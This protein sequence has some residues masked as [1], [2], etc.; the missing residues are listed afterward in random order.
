MSRV[1]P[2]TPQRGA[3]LPLPV[4]AALVFWTWPFW[5][6]ARVLD[7]PPTDE[8][9]TDEALLALAVRRLAAAHELLGYVL[10]AERGLDP[11][12]TLDA[13]LRAYH[14]ER[15]QLRVDPLRMRDALRA[16]LGTEPDIDVVALCAGVTERE[17]MDAECA[18]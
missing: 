4:R 11:D 9:P 7:R 3:D 6:A 5:L 13:R 10:A 12:G 2:H 16:V 15:R 17:V 18:R 14:A 1:A 8:A